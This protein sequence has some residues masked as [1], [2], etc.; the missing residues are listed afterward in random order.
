[1]D[2]ISWK[3]LEP[4]AGGVGEEERQLS[5]DGPIVSSGASQL[6]GQPKVCQPQLWFGL[7][8]VLCDAGR[9]S[10]R[11]GQRRA[12]DRP[13]EHPQAWWLWSHPVLIAIVPPAA[14]GAVTALLRVPM[15]TATI[16]FD[17]A[18]CV[19]STLIVDEENEHGLFPSREWLLMD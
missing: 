9:G 8:V 10:K 3:F 2:L 4:P 18:S 11:A 13:V 19:V 16:F 5:D 1:M 12:A 17:V 6:T 15:P 14:M 7:T